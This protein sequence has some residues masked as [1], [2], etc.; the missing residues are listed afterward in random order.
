[1]AAYKDWKSYLQDEKAE[2]YFTETG[3][4][5]ML[6]CVSPPRS[7]RSSSEPT[8]HAYPRPSV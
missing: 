6:G 8:T 4:L 2:A 1:M 5:W 7:S 3:A